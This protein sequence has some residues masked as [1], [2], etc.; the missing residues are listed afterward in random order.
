MTDSARGAS[1]ELPFEAALERL[2]ALVGRLEGG[3][4]EL[5]E[6]L[7]AFEEGVRLTRQCATRLE[8]AERRIEEL[9]ERGGEWFKRSFEGPGDDD[10]WT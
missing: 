8:D 1:D 5:E 3:D 2:E 10:E 6:A 9:V 4:L 7:A